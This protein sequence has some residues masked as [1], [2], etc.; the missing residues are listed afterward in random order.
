ML[1]ADLHPLGL[2]EIAQHPAARER[3]VEMPLVHPAHD[4]EIGRGHGSRQA[5]DAAPAD[6]QRLRL[7]GDGQLVRPVDHR[8]ALSRPALLRA[9]SQK[10]FVRVSSPILAW[11]I[12]TSTGGAPGSVLASAPNTPA[13]PSRS[14]VFQAV[15]WFG[16]TSSCCA[17]SASV[18]SP[19]MAARATF[20]LKAGLWFRRDRRVIVSPARQPSWPLSGRN[21]TYRP[22]RIRRASSFP[23]PALPGI[24][25]TTTLSDS[26][27]HR[28]PRRRRGRDPH[29]WAGLPSYPRH[30]SGV[31]CPLP[32]WTAAGASVGCFPATCSLPRNSGGSASTTSLSRP[33]QA[34]LTLRP[35]GSL[36]RPRRPSSRGF[37]LPGCPDRPLV[38]YQIKPTTIWVDP[39]STG[40]ARHL[41]A[42]N[43]PG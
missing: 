24:T 13:A 10:S 1:A 11:R 12:L 2:Q 42:L 15:I 33:A 7:A 3:E 23:P 38:S 6:G 18:F 40:D 29:A 4:G 34:S 39:P 19:W 17:S 41:G 16:W 27:Q 20:A 28:R 14:S 32:R 9:P 43:N 30:P 25:G 26:R 22:V 5:V 35:V 31:P 21:A 36:D 37:R 8:L